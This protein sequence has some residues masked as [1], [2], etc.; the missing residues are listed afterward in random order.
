MSTLTKTGKITNFKN[1]AAISLGILGAQGLGVAFINS[2]FSFVY[3]E[4]IGVSAAIVGVVLALA[5]LVDGVF[6]F[7]MGVVMDRFQT[8]HGKAKHWFLWMSIPLAISTGLVFYAPLNASTTVKVI[9]MVVIYNIYSLLVT[10]VRLPANTLPALISD[11]SKIR[12]TGSFCIAIWATLGGMI[13]NVMANPAVQAFGGGLDGYRK[14][15]VILAVIMGVFTFAAF[16]FVTEV[17]TPDG[18]KVSTQEKDQI[19]VL[20]QFKNLFKNKFWIIQ[21]GMTIPYYFSTGILM[22][23]MAYFSTYVLGDVSFVGIMTICCMGGMVAGTVIT[24]PLSRKIDGRLICIAAGILGIAGVI[25]ELMFVSSNLMIYFV[26][27]II[28]GLACGAMTGMDAALT[29]RTIDYGEWKNGVRQEGLCYSGKAV[30]QKISAALASSILGFA[31][32]ASGYVGGSGV[33]SDSVVSTLKTMVI[34]VPGILYVIYTISAY[35]FKLTDQRVG[36]IQA[37]LRAKRGEN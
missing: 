24:L 28:T 12:A 25:L 15:L 21:Q 35:F 36:E 9:Y 17:R 33:V 22:G 11:D 18:E 23:A 16:F 4:Y 6:D 14:F 27:L 29:A 37:E 1:Y 10:T 32:T 7:G 20:G 3:T 8:K 26:G 19:S 2:F 31:L 5:T 30:L 34:V 13:V